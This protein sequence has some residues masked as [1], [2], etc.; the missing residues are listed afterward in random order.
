MASGNHARG[1]QSWRFQDQHP[2]L[3]ER[4]RLERLPDREPARASACVAPAKPLVIDGWLRRTAERSCPQ[5][6]ADAARQ[7]CFVKRPAP[8]ACRGRRS[9]EKFT[10]ERLP[11][12]LDA[13]TEL[14]KNRRFKRENPQE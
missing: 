2:L 1:P 6:R 4:E 12:R 5:L 14:C 3:P 11:S 13:K 7:A 8:S 10:R 9:A